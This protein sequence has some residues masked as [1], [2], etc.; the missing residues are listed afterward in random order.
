MT[1][2]LAYLPI[3]DQAP[4]IETTDLATIIAYMVVIELTYPLKS[5]PLLE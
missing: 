4:M 3:Y 5:K 1:L 2:M